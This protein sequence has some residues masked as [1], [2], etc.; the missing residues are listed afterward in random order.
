MGAPTVIATVFMFAV[1][2]IALDTRAGVLHVSPSL[3]EMSRS[4][5]AS[6]LQRLKIVLLAALPGDPGRR[7]ARE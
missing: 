5:G 6:P 1:W 7:P 4:F 3:I 2:I